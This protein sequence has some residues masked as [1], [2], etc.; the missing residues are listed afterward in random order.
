MKCHCQPAVWGERGWIYSIYLYV[1][2]LVMMSDTICDQTG[3]CDPYAHKSVTSRISKKMRVPYCKREQL[4]Y[5]CG[6]K[7]S[8]IIFIQTKLVRHLQDHTCQK[9]VG[10]INELH[11]IA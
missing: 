3:E 2:A 4:G 6:A 5:L 8:V 9:T 7:P 10:H 11:I 1:S